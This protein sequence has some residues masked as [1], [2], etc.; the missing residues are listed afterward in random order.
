MATRSPGVSLPLDWAQAFARKRAILIAGTGYQYGDTD[1]LEYSERLYRE[2]ARELRAGTGTA[3]SV[4]KALVRAKRDLPRDDA[5]HPWHPREGHPGGDPLR[6]PDVRGER[7]P[8]AVAGT[9]GTGDPIATT[10]VTAE[11]AASLG[12]ATADLPISP[13]ADAATRCSSRTRPTTRCPAPPRSPSGCP[14]PNGV[15]TNPA[16]PALPLVARNVTRDGR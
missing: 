9:P 15:V 16:E 4:G 8:P 6:P 2:F 14:D 10:G 11:P 3:I 13:I 1:F 5:G 12:L 7:C